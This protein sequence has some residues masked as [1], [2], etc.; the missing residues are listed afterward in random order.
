MQTIFVSLLLILLLTVTTSADAINKASQS[1]VSRDKIIVK[2][3][4]HDYNQVGVW[5]AQINTSTYQDLDRDGFYQNLGISFDLDTSAEYREVF[6][7]VWLDSP[8][9]NQQLIYTSDI[10]GLTGD[11]TLDAQQIAIQFIDD[12]QQNYYQLEV[13]IIDVETAATIF[14]LGQYD[15]L[16]LQDLALEGQRSDQDQTLSI[17]ATDIKLNH[18][19]NHN[20]YFQQMSVSFDIDVPYGSTTLIAEFYLDDILLFTT[21]PF[22]ITGSRTSDTQYFDIEMDSGL[23]SGYYNLDIHLIDAVDFS[24]RHHISA[25]DWIVFKDLPLESK[26]SDRA[27]ATSDIEVHVEHSGG[28][29]G[30]G[31]AGLMLLIIRRRLVKTLSISSEWPSVN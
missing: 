7:E 28:S 22:D 31:M 2:Q 20:G 15:S 14:S 23:T 18:D 27:P 26:H 11:S 10:I 21:F 24:R 5:L 25:L 30:W 17:Y 9:G 6:V 16:Q 3:K 29:V 19:D 8:S 1:P 12:L 4:H 13:V